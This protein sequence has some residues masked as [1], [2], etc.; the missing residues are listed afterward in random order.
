[1]LHGQ[2]Y[3]YVK[4]TL[5]STSCKKRNIY[6]YKYIE[7]ILKNPNGHFTN[8]NGNTLWHLGLLERWFQLN[9]DSQKTHLT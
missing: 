9:I 8:L 5:R 7:R 3:D 4:M 1:M 6:N 2:F